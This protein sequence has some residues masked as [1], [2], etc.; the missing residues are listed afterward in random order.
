MLRVMETK[1]NQDRPESSRK[2]CEICL[3]PIEIEDEHI[4]EQ[5][6]CF[7]CKMCLREY[8][9]TRIDDGQCQ[10]RCPS[11]NCSNQKPI[12]FDEIN[13]FVP[14][15]YR[16]KLKKLIESKYQQCDNN[17]DVNHNSI[18]KT[19]GFNQRRDLHDDDEED[20]N[21]GHQMIRC[22]FCRKRFSLSTD[23]LKP[24]VENNKHGD[25]PIVNDSMDNIQSTSLSSS[26]SKVLIMKCSK[27]SNIVCTGCRSKLSD[28]LTKHDCSDLNE[29]I[30][31]E[32]DIKRCPNCNYLIQRDGGCAQIFCHNCC[33]IFCWHCLQS[34][35]NDFLLFHYDSG[36]CKNKLGH[37]RLTIFL[38]RLQTFSVCVGISFLVLIT[39]PIIIAMLPCFLT[40]KCHGCC[41]CRCRRKRK[42][43]IS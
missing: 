2:I 13:R 18:Q 43:S 12:S 5:C 33:H 39:S 22:P 1:L 15:E 19:I 40:K 3:D 31:N 23:C 38:N 42:D 35:E 21:A 25:I 30:L 34:L 10:I 28:P 36:P 8:F 9:R 7:F 4:L 24:L 26:P 37:S 6:K 16:L 32:F 27:C 11:F 14:N 29:S 20:F 17:F 41:F